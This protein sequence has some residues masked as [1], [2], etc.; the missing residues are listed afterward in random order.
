MLVG[1][2]ISICFLYYYLGL[3]GLSLSPLKKEKKK[4]QFW[5]AFRHD[6]VPK[7]MGLW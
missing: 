5:G 4:N 3:W 2:S 6:F 1:G 7:T